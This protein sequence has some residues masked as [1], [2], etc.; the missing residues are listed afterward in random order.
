MAKYFKLKEV[1]KKDIENGL[2]AVFNKE[3]KEYKDFAYADIK[4]GQIRY[5]LPESKG[6]KVIG[7]YQ[8]IK[9]Y[10]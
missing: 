8:Q 6:R 5:L 10:K 4:K 9:S 1:P 2:I 7:I 3:T